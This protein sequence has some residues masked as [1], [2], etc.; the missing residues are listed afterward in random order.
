MKTIN[1]SELR[2]TTKREGSQV[3]LINLGDEVLS[4]N[5]K[6]S[7][8]GVTKNRFYGRSRIFKAARKNSQS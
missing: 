5:A 8:S 4:D 6:S 3:T 1:K 7:G 2:P